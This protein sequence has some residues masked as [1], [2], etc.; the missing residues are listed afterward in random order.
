M[1]KLTLSFK[2]GKKLHKLDFPVQT[3]NELDNNKR[4]TSKQ[5]AEL[6]KI[7]KQNLKEVKGHF[8][9]AA[10]KLDAKYIISDIV[11]NFFG[12]NFTDIII[13]QICN[14]ADV[15]YTYQDKAYF[16]N[17]KI[18]AFYNPIKN[19]IYLDTRARNLEFD[20]QLGNL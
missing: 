7:I 5:K 10:Y 16:I 4:L 18:K 2:I 20:V 1:A 14:K 9:D 6:K 15:T 3:L 11:D 13:G 12:V 19:K 8:N 17:E